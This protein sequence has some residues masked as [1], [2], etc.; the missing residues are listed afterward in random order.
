MLIAQDANRPAAA[1]QFDRAMKS[2]AAI[3]QLH[4]G[5]AANFPHVRVNEAISE[6][7]ING[8]V[9]DVTDQPRQD[10]REQF[11]IAQMT[12]HKDDRLTGLQFAVNRI[13]I[14]DFNLPRHFFERHC[15]DLQTANQIAAQLLKMTAHETAHL[16]RRF[17]IAEGNAQIAQSKPA[18]TSQK[19]PGAETKTL[20]GDKKKPKRKRADNGR[21]CAIQEI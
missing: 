19:Y 12:E 16:A 11:P 20:S 15:A 21:S 8:A 17:F 7:L 2:F 13:D 5:P 9:A 10:L 14:F 18:I 1:Q 6:L 3:E 4:A